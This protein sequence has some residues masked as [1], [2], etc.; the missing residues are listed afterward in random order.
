MSSVALAKVSSEYW[1][2]LP[3]KCKVSCKP[4]Y[5]ISF[6]MYSSLPGQVPGPKLERGISHTAALEY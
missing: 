4:S 6:A 1:P 5:A 3:A 2:F